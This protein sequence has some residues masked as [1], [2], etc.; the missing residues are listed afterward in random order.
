MGARGGR[1][2][3]QKDIDWSTL[4]DVSHARDVGKQTTFGFPPK[5]VCYIWWICDKDV[6]LTESNHFALSSI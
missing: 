4:P 6:S 2:E 1:R 3:H 5:K